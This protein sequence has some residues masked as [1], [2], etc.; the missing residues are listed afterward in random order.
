MNDLAACMTIATDI[1]K[2][3]GPSED[4]TMW[5]V[6]W[7]CN[8]DA[9]H[10]DEGMLV[11]MKYI[12]FMK[13]NEKKQF[14]NLVEEIDLATFARLKARFQDLDVETNLEY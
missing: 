6:G 10:A 14:D 5:E 4:Y 12:G 7:R 11:S 3:T 1:E 8:K 9:V 2:I 13:S